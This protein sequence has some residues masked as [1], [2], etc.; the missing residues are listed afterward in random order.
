MQCQKL[1]TFKASVL[2]HTHTHNIY[3]YI[4]I[5]IWKVRG[6]KQNMKNKIFRGR[7]CLYIHIIPKFNA[8]FILKNFTRFL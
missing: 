6:C 2:T 5:Y 4:Y 3:I 1:P 8:L 7:M